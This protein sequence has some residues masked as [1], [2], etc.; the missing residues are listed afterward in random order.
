M[1]S[2]CTSTRRVLKPGGTFYFLEHVRAPAE[3]SH[4][5]KFHDFMTNS[6]IWPGKNF[7]VY[8][9]AIETKY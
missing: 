4:M 3:D 6:G 7:R 5:R 1:C 2:R 9:T 8:F